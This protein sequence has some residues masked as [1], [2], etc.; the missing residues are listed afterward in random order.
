MLRCFRDIQRSI[1][2]CLWVL[3]IA[4]PSFSQERTEKRLKDTSKYLQN[5]VADTGNIVVDKPLLDIY[6]RLMRYQTAGQDIVNYKSGSEATPEDYLTIAVNNVSVGEMSDLARYLRTMEAHRSDEILRIQRNELCPEGDSCSL[7]YDVEWIKGPDA[8]MK[9]V[10]RRLKDIDEY[11]TYNIAV[12]FHGKTLLHQ[13]VIAY[14]K[15]ERTEKPFV[16]YDGIIPQINELASEKMPLAIVKKMEVRA[17]RNRSPKEDVTKLKAEKIDGQ[18]LESEDEA[19]PIGTIIGDNRILSASEPSSKSLTSCT[20]P[21]SCPTQ[22]GS[23]AT[24]YTSHIVGGT[25]YVGAEFLVQL[26]DGSQIPSA[27]K[28]S[29]R[30]VSESFSNIVDG[31]YKTYLGPY[32]V[33]SVMANTFTIDSNNQYSDVVET[34]IEWISY[35]MNIPGAACAASVTQSLKITG[36]NSSGPVEYEN[37]I[38]ERQIH[39]IPP[40]RIYSVSRDGAVATQNWP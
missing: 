33:N 24:K 39:V 25:T 40:A 36:C 34:P 10:Y 1:L 7:S 14:Y 17:F 28:Y 18:P 13:G 4:N 29:G 8:G 19:E 11:I 15:S 38:C 12:S 31:C 22:E 16:V 27:G 37:H 32:R 26:F 6:V 2:I 3:V 21:T 35:Y 20:P 23:R 9:K 5:I 30:T